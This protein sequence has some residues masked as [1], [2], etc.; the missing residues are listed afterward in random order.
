MFNQ[1]NSVQKNRP[2]ALAAESTSTSPASKCICTCEVSTT[3]A[4]MAFDE[5]IATSEAT[6]AEVE[7][8]VSPAS[9]GFKVF[10]NEWYEECSAKASLRLA[11]NIYW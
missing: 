10:I 7:I 2:C 6:D 1:P 5:E 8:E 3:E 4:K 11:L 9:G